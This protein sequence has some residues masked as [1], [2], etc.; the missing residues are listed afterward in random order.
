MTEKLKDLEIAIGVGGALI[1]SE[2]F[3]STMLTSPVTA[4]KFFQT[5][6][7]QAKV[8]RMLFLASGASLLAAGGISYLIKEKSPVIFTFILCLFYIVIYTKALNQEL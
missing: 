2:H 8:R 5:P 3:F 6:E 4:E 7:E 1:F